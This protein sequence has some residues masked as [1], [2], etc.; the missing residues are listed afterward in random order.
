MCPDLKG[1][2]AVTV[3][4]IDARL[5]SARAI[6]TQAGDVALEYF[7]S[8]DTLTIDR[9]GHQ[10]L[11]SEADRN[12]ETLVRGLIREAFPDDSIIGEEDAPE[13]GI[14][15]FTWV[16]DP[17]DGTAN[18]V[19]GIPAWTVVLAV[20]DAT[21]IVAG[22]V[23]DPVHGEMCHARTGGGAYCNDRKLGVTPGAKLTDGSVG[24]GF[25]ARTAT[26]GVVRAI[27]MLTEQGGVFYRNASGALMLSYVAQGKLLGYVESH[28]NAWDCLAGQLLIA[29]AGG[30][31]EAQDTADMLRNGGRVVAGAPGVFADLV[32]IADAAF[33][34]G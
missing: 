27:E 4:P 12:V 24:I 29:E 21:G 1:S 25:S 23:H 16:I 32:A 17:I 3:S 34:R 5:A 22:I 19:R 11:V 15:G 6:A 2:F 26:D 13:P 20:T 14:S 9:K 18:F 8:F 10:D 28:M 30:R 31:I 7:R 33:S